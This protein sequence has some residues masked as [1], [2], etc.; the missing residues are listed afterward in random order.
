[1]DNDIV[2]SR[3]YLLIILLCNLSSNAYATR[4]TYRNYLN[5]FMLKM[6]NRMSISKE[7]VPTYIQE[8]LRKNNNFIESYGFYVVS[9]PNNDE[10]PAYLT[11]KY[12]M[13]KELNSIDILEESES[14]SYKQI[15]KSKLLVFLLSNSENMNSIVHEIYDVLS[16]N[17]NYRNI[18]ILQNLDEVLDY[19]KDQNILV[20]NELNIYQ[21]R[22]NYFLNYPIVNT[23]TP[24]E[25]CL[26]EY[27]T[28]KASLYGNNV[29]L[30]SLFKT[31][32]NN[33]NSNEV[34]EML[35]VLG[36]NTF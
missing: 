28:I 35:K 15:I 32:S 29:N 9:Q 10:I 6:L 33:I 22:S 13:L 5:D 8:L 34:K 23:M 31:T 19:L 26:R 7:N 12:P 30:L 18:I 4:K 3:Y 36:L 1:M 2:I 16:K 21:N 24:I 17:R 20:N 25:G 27:R 11:H 14:Y